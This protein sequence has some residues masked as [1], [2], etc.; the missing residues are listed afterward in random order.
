[1]PKVKPKEGDKYNIATAVIIFFQMSEMIRKES[2]ETKL[3]NLS[4]Y[5][6]PDWVPSS[7]TSSDE[8]NSVL[9][10]Q[11][12]EYQLID[13]KT[14]QTFTITELVA[15][16]LHSYLLSYL[17]ASNIQ[18]ENQD[19]SPNLVELIQQNAIENSNYCRKIVTWILHSHIP[20]NL[21]TKEFKSNEEIENY[22]IEIFNQLCDEYMRYSPGPWREGVLVEAIRGMI[23]QR[24]SRLFFVIDD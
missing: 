13:D 9:Q 18:I 15:T 20:S 10:L 5:L 22:M 19:K 7:G 21:K 11:Y 12:P 14:N 4:Q 16:E 17:H 24:A 2:S 1:M 8:D 23:A 3:Q 6:S